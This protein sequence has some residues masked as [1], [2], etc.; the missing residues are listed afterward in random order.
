M[1]EQLRGKY[2]YHTQ[3]DLTRI[4]NAGYSKSI[5]PLSGAVADYIQNYLVRDKHLG[6]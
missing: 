1:P 3:A 2:Q 4:R 6:D 5:T